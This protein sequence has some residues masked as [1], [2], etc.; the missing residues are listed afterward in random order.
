[1]E[2]RP[3]LAT[4]AVLYGVAVLYGLI[5]AGSVGQDLAI[6]KALRDNVTRPFEK[7]L[8]VHQTWP[9][10]RV[11]PRETTWLTVHGVRRNGQAEVLDVLPGE[12]D[13]NGIR[14]TYDRLGKLMRN[15]AVH[16]REK[17]RMGIV[18]WVCRTEKA[19][20][21]PLHTVQLRRHDARTPPP[22]SGRVARET[23]DVE[24][25]RFKR[26]NCR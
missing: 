6:G 22:G 15:A 13:P 26:W 18:R 2:H 1:M 12:P 17:L 9:M 14:A 25:E 11:A 7:V 10:F 4:R 24:H 3:P 8:G 20:G 23:F 5:I 21:D 16:R 19:A